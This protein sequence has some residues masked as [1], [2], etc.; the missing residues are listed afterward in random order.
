MPDPTLLNTK[1]RSY[2]E[3]MSPAA[4]TMLVRAMRNSQ[5][6]GETA[7]VLQAMMKAASAIDGAVEMAVQVSA[8][9]PAMTPFLPWA[10]RL[11][12]AFFAPLQP[13]VVDLAYSTKIVGRIQRKSLDG[14]WL[15]ITRDILAADPEALAAPTGSEG[16]AN[17]EHSAKK[18]R[19]VLTPKLESLLAAGDVQSKPLRR[20]AAQLGSEMALLDLFDVV[21][22]FKNEAAFLNLTGQLPQ[23]VSPLDLSDKSPVTDLVKTAVETLQLNPAFVA[24]PIIRRTA[25]AAPVAIMTLPLCNVSEPKLVVGSR[26]AGIVDAVLAE[27][28]MWVNRFASHLSDREAR[29]NALVDLR[30]YHELVRQIEV[31]IQPAEV[32]GWHR[33]LGACCKEM[34]DLIARDLEQL[35][36]L[37]RRALRVD[38]A[39]GRF[40]GTFDEMTAEDAEFGV[41]LFSE[42]RNA[43]DSLALNELVTKQRRQIE[44]TTESLTARLMAELKA[45]DGGEKPD[46]VRAVDAAIRMS[47]A[48]FGDDYAIHLRRS[49]DLAMTKSGKLAK[50]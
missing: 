45:A 49:R 5:E 32:G 2:M 22:I 27:V 15:L 30:E 37:I 44:Q 29:A 28:Q 20:L 50:A 12:N 8:D 14:I 43:L 31:G 21:Y 18:L 16:A 23:I 48:V 38:A 4:R 7:P 10:E 47:S 19:R 1:M 17:V 46:L 33:R 42:V 13:F 39:T 6:R 24:V 40:L 41:R 26:Y 35:P 34:S 3:A 9:A 11:Q 25:V 36:G